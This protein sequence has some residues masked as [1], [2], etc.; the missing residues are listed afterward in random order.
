MS[1]LSNF[2][3]YQPNNISK[4]PLPRKHF[5]FEVSEHNNFPFDAM[6]SFK[7]TNMN[8]IY[9]CKYSNRIFKRTLSLD[10]ILEIS[11][12]LESSSIIALKKCKK[13]LCRLKEEQRAEREDFSWKNFRKCQSLPNLYINPFSYKRMISENYI[14]LIR[15]PLSKP[16]PLDLQYFQAHIS[17]QVNNH[18]DGFVKRRTEELENRTELL[19]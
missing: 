17:R 5:K 3:Q 19:E 6:N 8:V 18:S 4:P 13:S 10:N 14:N 12:N 11:K 9:N 7:S 15:Q 16:T 2:E 1:D